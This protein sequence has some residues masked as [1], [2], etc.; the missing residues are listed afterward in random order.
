MMVEIGVGALPAPDRQPSR[1]QT[2]T[3]EFPD[4]HAGTQHSRVS[5]HGRVPVAV[6]V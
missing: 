6:A 4:S 1:A 2:V 5:Q 3:A